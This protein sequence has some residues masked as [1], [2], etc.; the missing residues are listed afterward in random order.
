LTT[1]SQCVSRG[2]EK[3]IQLVKKAPKEF[4]EQKYIIK[5]WCLSE[6]NINKTPTKG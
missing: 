2:A 5:Y 6:N 1:Y 4:D 3:T